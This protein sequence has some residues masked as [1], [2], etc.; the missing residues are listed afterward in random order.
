[1][2]EE[3]VDAE[4]ISEEIDGVTVVRNEDVIASQ[5]HGMSKLYL[6]GPMDGIENYNHEL[7]NKV[8][9]EFRDANF[10]VCTPS[11]FFDGDVTRERKEYMREAV[12]YLLEAD[13]I[14]LLPGW[15][16]SKGA[17][18]EAAIATELD[19]IIVEYVENDEQAAK[20][21]PVGGTFT[22]LEREHQVVLTPIDEN[23]DEVPAPLSSFTPVE[24]K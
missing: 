13:T 20:L 15:E 2:S 7:F 17:R 19:L 8:A 11:E 3:I 21:P 23:G 9:K 1:M 10:A 4:I 18:L 12:K 6:S 5:E 16:D 24:E 14:V 22:S